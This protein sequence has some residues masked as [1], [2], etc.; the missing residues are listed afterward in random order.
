MATFEVNLRRRNIPSADL[1][2]DLRRVAD[3]VE[4][5][6]VTAVIYSKKGKFGVNTMLRRFSS[7]NEALKEAGLQINNVLNIPDNELFE[8]LIE[9]WE[10]F[11]RQPVGRD[12]DKSKGVSKF[13]LGTYER[14]FGSW[15][16]ALTAFS[17]FINKTESQ[18]STATPGAT[19]E[20]N[21]GKRSRSPRKINWRLRAVVLIRDN[22][23]CRICGASP[24][25][26]P[27]VT[28]HVDHIKPWS[29]GGETVAD[30]LQTLCSV[31]NVG[32][33]DEILM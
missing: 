16:K 14:R 12:L 19:R 3:E 6:S 10:K 23:I 15:N 7:W 33:S 18:T 21:S 8:N 31:C 26:D 11:G 30:N 2:E 32:K 28:L 25:K 9:V 20:A 24:S 13:A 17:E 4:G 29:K 1:I 22:C 5:S 27:A